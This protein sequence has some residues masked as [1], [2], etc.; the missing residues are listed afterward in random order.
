MDSWTL[1]TFYVGFSVFRRILGLSTRFVEWLFRLLLDQKKKYIYIYFPRDSFY[2]F[3]WDHPSSIYKNRMLT[4]TTTDDLET[5][6]ARVAIV[7]Q[8]I[9]VA[10][11]VCVGGGGTAAHVDYYFCATSRW[12]RGLVRPAYSPGH[13][14]GSDASYPSLFGLLQFLVGTGVYFRRTVP[15]VGGTSF[16][17]VLSVVTY[18]PGTVPA[19]YYTPTSRPRVLWPSMGN[20]GLLCHFWP[21]PR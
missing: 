19:G 1:Y 4:I 5:V 12:P 2:Y 14:P 21:A 13:P 11:N 8:A 16:A 15:F 6:R 17:V 9:S 10:T 18:P 7:L 20:R 3:T